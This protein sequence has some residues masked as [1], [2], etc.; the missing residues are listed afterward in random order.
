MKSAN[1]A[2]A[3]EG[4]CGGYFVTADDFPRRAYLKPVKKLEDHAERAVAAREKI[5][6]DLAFD[7]SLPVPPALLTAQPGAPPLPG[8]AVVSLVMYPV[9][10]AWEHVRW[11]TPDDHV[12]QAALE[13]VFAESAAGML[14]FDTWLGQL[15]HD[16]HPHNIVWGYDPKDL[17]DTRLVYL[18]FAR[19]L[20]CLDCWEEG[21]WQEVVRAPFPHRLTETLNDARLADAISKVGALSEESIQKIVMRVPDDYLDSGRKSVVVEGL[22][23]RRRQLEATLL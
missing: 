14:V 21:K 22:L 2:G 13:R 5:A 6:S 20:G 9:Q 1:Q 3:L 10:W 15:D 17:A 23:G 4:E 16:D 8:G 11:K 19:S 18:D 7:L 12:V